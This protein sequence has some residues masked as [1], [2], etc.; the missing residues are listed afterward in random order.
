MKMDDMLVALEAAAARKSI[1]VSYENVGG[2]PGAGGLCKVKGEWRVIVDKRATPSERVALVGNAL[3]MFPIDDLYL[4][5]EV[6]D[7]IE[8]LRQARALKNAS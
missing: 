6:R 5:P 2:E 7:L 8:K 1:R 3:A 4:P